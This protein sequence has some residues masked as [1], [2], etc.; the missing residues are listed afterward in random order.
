MASPSQRYPDNAAGDFY[1]D[2]TCIDC[3]AC[4][5]IA[6]ATFA[7]AAD[8]SFVSS[9]PE[10][11]A[12]RRRAL[13]ALVACPTGSIGTVSRQDVRPALAEFPEPVAEN[14]SFC[15]FTSESSFGAW[16]YFLER[17]EGNV[18][19][20]SPKAVN[21]LLSHF[22]E[23]GGIAT[24]FLTHRDDV[25]DHAAFARRFGCERIL[26]ERD[27]TRSTGDV[28]RTISGDD[29]VALSEDLLVIPT[30]GH[31][32]GH[33]V[34]LYRKKFLFTGDHLAW[35]SRRNGLIAFRD[36]CWYSWEE[37]T[38]SMERLLDYSFEWVLPGHGAWHHAG[39][40]SA[41]RRDLE[42][43]VRWMKGAR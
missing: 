35:S 26:H 1:V 43:C 3:D 24:M 14:V 25:A 19:V 2:R 5:R 17:P 22:E 38:R 27:V 37:Q 4:R 23:R 20:D 33:A 29:P 40:S 13:M 42:A 28:E 21:R 30:P 34:L 7:E 16:S 39:S 15:G 11:E 36:A 18:L 12:E 6:P 32:R 41:M 8:H 31:T 9:Q 10:G